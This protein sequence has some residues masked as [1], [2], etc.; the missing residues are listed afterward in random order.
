MSE[1]NITQK[2]DYVS[3]V[4]FKAPVYFKKQTQIL[5]RKRVLKKNGRNPCKATA[6]TTNPDTFL[7]SQSPTF[8]IITKSSTFENRILSVGGNRRCEKLGWMDLFRKMV[9]GFFGFLLAISCP[10]TPLSNSRFLVIP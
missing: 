8:S 2:N 9:D 4:S 10:P 7:E 3:T 5:F 1:F 6:T